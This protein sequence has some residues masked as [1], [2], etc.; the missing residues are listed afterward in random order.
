VIVRLAFSSGEKKTCE[1][2]SSSY[3]A[4]VSRRSNRRRSS[5]TQN[6][7]QLQPTSRRATKI[8][9]TFGLG[10]VL[11]FCCAYLYLQS[12]LHGEKFRVLVGAVVSDVVDA[13][14]KFSP[15]EWQRTIVSTEGFSAEGSKSI[16]SIQAEDLTAKIRLLHMFRG[17]WFIDHL[18]L[19]DLQ[20]ELNMCGEQS[21][22]ETDLDTGVG[23]GLGTES[24]IVLEPENSQNQGFLAD[25]LPSR[26]K[27]QSLEVV[28]LGLQVHSENGVVDLADGSLR[29]TR[30]AG[31]K[32]SYDFTLS[33]AH[34]KAP[35]LD[36]PV[37]LD[38]AKGKYVDKNLYLQ[39]SSS[40]VFRDAQLSLAGELAKDRYKWFGTLENVD[41][42]ELVVEDW[43]RRLSGVLRTEFKVH[44]TQDG[45]STRGVVSLDKG[46]LTALPILDRIAAYTN[47][48][49]FRRLVLTECRL[50]YTSEDKRIELSDIV[51]VSDG[52]V[53][54][55][56]D[57]VINN[58]N[59]DGDFRVGIVPGLLAHIPGAETKVFLRGEKGLRWAP[60]RITGT[61]D[62]PREDLS[63]RIIAAAGGRIIELIPETGIKAVKLAQEKATGL[64]KAAIDFSNDVIEQGDEI[65]EEG[66]DIIRDGV[67]GALDL[68]P[69][70]N[71]PKRP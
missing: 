8:V 69:G 4:K 15:L 70:F 48:N 26:A 16:R 44:S 46:V 54:V 65:L 24:V 42:E 21:A 34:I 56:G 49:R 41:V 59:L 29:A 19:S 39:Q 1:S 32:H 53:R 58:G 22:P 35:W 33:D 57:L 71:S 11:I 66:V 68:I 36:R 63:E 25:I 50:N 12:Y 51:I 6:P 30:R 55:I 5:H 7:R 27:L 31:Q 67:G 13:D 47:T 14:V 20:V 37:K 61:I 45:F 9:V 10:I 52:L 40:R 28:R 60:L 3:F 23:E 18:E 38:S 64:P 43:Q 62:K 2:G 17:E